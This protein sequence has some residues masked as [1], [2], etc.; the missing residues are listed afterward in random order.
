MWCC[1][2]PRPWRW[3]FAPRGQLLD[4]RRAESRQDT[5]LAEPRMQPLGLF[6]DRALAITTDI[7]EKAQHDL[8]VSALGPAAHDPAVPPDR[9]SRVAGTVEH[10]GPVRAEVPVAT[11]PAHHA[12][13]EARKQRSK[14]FRP[15]G[16]HQVASESDA[17]GAVELDLDRS[18]RGEGAPDVGQGPAGPPPD[19][20][21]RGR[22]K[23]FEP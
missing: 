10:R 4:E 12:G 5:S 22:P 7:L 13:I 23:G 3:R 9:R 20:L 11:G 8:A 6:L 19:V 16:R 2:R 17:S 1:A 14:W 21:D 18:N 15:A